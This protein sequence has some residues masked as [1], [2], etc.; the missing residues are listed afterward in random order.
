[1]P[2]ANDAPADVTI[3]GAGIIGVCCALSALERGLSV[4]IIDRDAPG[5][6]TSSGNAGVIS[7]W[8][9]VPQ[10][11]P[12]VW[13]GVPRWLLDPKGPVKVRW[14]DLASILPWTLAFMRNA[15]PAKVAGI[16]D[17]MDLL[18]RDNV[19]AYRWYLAGTGHENLIAD[20]WLVTLFRGDLRPDLD[21]WP[22]K[23]RRE[24]GAPVEIIDAPTL[25]EIEPA[26]SR[27]YRSAVVIKGQARARSPST[28]CKALAEK[29]VAQGAELQLNE[30]EALLPE[31]DGTVS[32]KTPGGVISTKRL[33][34]SAGIWSAK[35]LRPLG[36]KLPLMAERGYHL[37]F[38]EPGV[39]VNHSVQDM[40]AKIFLSAMTEGVRVAG[41]AEF[42][43]LNAPPNYARARALEP[44]V[45][46]V[47][48]SLNTASKREWMGIRPSFPDSLPAI[49]PLPGFPSLFAAF[50]HSHYG[51]GMA[52]AT[53][54]IT[55]DHLTGMR[56]N[57][58]YSMF[59]PMRFPKCRD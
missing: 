6:A 14:R 25:Q 40:S 4:T 21:D 8:S 33:V 49:G 42:A 32:L 58:D 10:C 28:L 52:P 16:S 55:A 11:L 39:T 45:K 38:P 15:T 30:V 41:T 5:E 24:R 20:S 22:W 29:A 26:V 7:P 34:L 46:R 2:H 1:M 43:D 35:L 57:T 44:L 19:E 23:L 51:L 31:A 50:G 13:K 27:A 3:L 36:I 48:P 59:A 12:G 47:L 17:A 56:S 54:R 53:A 37:E 9:C 18:M